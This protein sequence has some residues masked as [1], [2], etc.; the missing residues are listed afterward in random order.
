MPRFNIEI[1]E[2]RMAQI[3]RIMEETGCKTYKELLDA[4]I[5]LFDLLKQ[6]RME[7][8]QVGLFEPTTET[9]KEIVVAQ[10]EYAKE[11]AVEGGQDDEN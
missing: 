5:S 11:K 4:S 9:F 6:K 8:Y 10:F 2:T 3:K 1:T 7:G